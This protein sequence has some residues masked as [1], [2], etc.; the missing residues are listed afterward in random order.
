MRILAA[1]LASLAAAGT[2]WAAAR[3]PARVQVAAQEYSF[4]LS[5]TTLKAGPAIV[6]LVNYGEDPHDLRLQR[7]GARHVY[8][9]PLVEPG[10]RYDLAARL[11]PGRY[12]LW[13][14]VADHRARGMRA[15]L[16]V[17]G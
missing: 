9:S 11:A 3:A 14:S 1:L 10:D 12:V 7:V 8:G 13:C 6:E 17:R 5:R 4:A 16:L 2:A 15:T